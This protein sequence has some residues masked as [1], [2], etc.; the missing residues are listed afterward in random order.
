MTPIERTYW[1]L[2]NIAR[3]IKARRESQT[4]QV[5]LLAIVAFVIMLIVEAATK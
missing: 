1:R 5:W 2:H 3:M 4:L